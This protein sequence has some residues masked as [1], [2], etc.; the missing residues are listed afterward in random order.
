[1]SRGIYNKENK[2]SNFKT[3][4]TQNNFTR[5]IPIF[6]HSPRTYFFKQLK[7]PQNGQQLQQ[8]KIQHKI[9]K[10]Y[11]SGLLSIFLRFD[12]KFS[13]FI[14]PNFS[15]K[16]PFQSCALMNASCRRHR[17][18]K[19]PRNKCFCLDMNRNHAVRIDRLNGNMTVLSIL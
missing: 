3:L 18:K 16:T 2:F 6:K 10:I 1:M 15:G 12:P 14:T 4:N 7:H 5:V 13:F 11:Y 9:V 19:K 8:Q 17:D